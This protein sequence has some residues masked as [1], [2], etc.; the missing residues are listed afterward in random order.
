MTIPETERN[1]GFAPFSVYTPTRNPEAFALPKEEEITL[2]E[3][4]YVSFFFIPFTFGEN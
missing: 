2:K 4:R 3:R 1:L